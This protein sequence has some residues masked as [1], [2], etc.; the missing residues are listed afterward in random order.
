VDDPPQ[1]SS[2]G[3]GASDDFR[4]LLSTTI[5]SAGAA[6]VI[7][8]ARAADAPI[9][10]A[11]DAFSALTGYS[12][13]EVRGRNCRFLQGA[14][15]DSAQ[16][17]RLREAVG[18]G[19]GVALD[20]LNYRKDGSTFWNALSVSPVRDTQGEVAYMLGVQHDVTARKTTELGLESA[21]AHRTTALDLAL[22]QK[23]ALLHEVDH[24]VKNNLQLISSLLLLQSRRVQDETAR[25]VLRG[26]LE[27]VSAV[28]T[29]HRRLFQSEDMERFDVSEFVRDLTGDLV[30]AGRRPEVRIRL[31]LERAEVAASQAA[32]AALIINEL[33]GNALKHA[34]PEERSGIVDVGIR[35]RGAGFELSIADDGVGL[36]A[37]EDTI[38]GFGLTIAHL[39]CKQLRAELSFEATQPGVRALV[40]LTKGP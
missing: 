38:R 1:K 36:P 31:D 4:D 20:I 37:P 13:A 14:Q 16:V 40:R 2:L 18:A 23:S 30:A 5:R 10:F 3:P 19:D 26:M 17:G 33:I 35:R 15:T 24:R 32:P 22:Q 27:R 11:N 8:D 7:T 28:A 39:L 12:A 21:V 6:M 29:V 25:A 9:V 34:F